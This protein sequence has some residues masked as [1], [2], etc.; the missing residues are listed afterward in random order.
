MASNMVGGRVLKR[1]E[2]ELAQRKVVLRHLPPDFTQE[3]FNN[4]IEDLPKPVFCYF[5]PGNPLLGDCGCARGYIDLPKD[6]DLITF[7]DK[8]DGCILESEKGVKYRLIVELAPYQGIPKGK[9]KADVRCGTIEQ[10]QDYK[11]FFDKYEVV[12]DPLPPVDLSYLEEVEK[13]KVAEIQATPLV[14]F[15]RERKAATKTAKSSKKVVLYASDV[16]RKRSDKTK[17]SDVAKVK[18]KET[19]NKDDGNKEDRSKKSDKIR[20]D[21]KSTV[22][23][24]GRNKRTE[25]AATKQPISVEAE[26]RTKPVDSH[27]S[28]KPIKE[29]RK[30]KDRPDQQFYSPRSGRQRGESWKDSNKYSGSRNSK[31]SYYKEGHTY[32]FEDT[33]DGYEGPDH[34]GSKSN[35]FTGGKG[36]GRGQST[37]ED[38]SRGRDY[39]RRQWSLQS[40]K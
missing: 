8:Y 22:I 21:E 35:S 31:S 30:S 37:N 13:N 9:H 6:V 4:I 17:S 7:R 2:K 38:H 36:H 33:D 1:A 26:K 40:S 24:S 27:G 32:Q 16:K 39:T 5:V 18:T 15:L 29:K 34:Y 25:D 12:A 10:D 11:T 14:D 28:N 23:G 19:R 3:N 20:S